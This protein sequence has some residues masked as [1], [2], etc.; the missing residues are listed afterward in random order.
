MA[1]PQA[2]PPQCDANCVRAHAAM[3]ADACAP[4]NEAQAPSDFDWITRPTPGIFQQADHSSPSDSV[5]R[6]RGDSILFMSADK[7]WLRV[8]Y[9][10]AYDVNARAVV[11]VHVH[12]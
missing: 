3:A 8:N 9:E 6:F 2:A 4:R 12:S 1:A 7:S 5:F 11:F 10:C